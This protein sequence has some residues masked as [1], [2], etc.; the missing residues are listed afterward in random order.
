MKCNRAT[1]ARL[2]LL[3]TSTSTSVLLARAPTR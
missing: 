2:W 1:P 3:V